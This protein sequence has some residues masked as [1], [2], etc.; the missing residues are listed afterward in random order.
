MKKNNNGN[1]YVLIII[2]LFLNNWR[3]QT[4]DLS[5]PFISH[6]LMSQVHFV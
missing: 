4:P 3:I 2:L 5:Y 6:S 1:K